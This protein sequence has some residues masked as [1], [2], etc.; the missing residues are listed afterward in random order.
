MNA[1]E[2]KKSSGFMWNVIGGGLVACQSAF[3]MFLAARFYSQ[4]EAGMISSA[5][6]IAVLAFTASRYGMRNYQVT[7][8]RDEFTFRSYYYSRHITVIAVILLVLVYLGVSVYF[9]DYSFNKSLLVLEIVLLRSI[10]SFEDVYLG[11]FQQMGYFAIG[12]RI[13]ALR[14]MALLICMC[15]GMMCRLSLSAVFLCGIVISALMDIFL[16]HEKKDYLFLNDEN[17]TGNDQIVKL[18]K[19]CFPLCLGT[20]LAIYASNIPKYVAD[21]YLD[22]L[23]QAIVGYLMLPIFVIALF[24][25]FI[26]TP[27]IKKLGDLWN[28]KEHSEFYKR[29]ICQS[30]LII[31][32]TIL[33][34]VF[35]LVIGLPILS[36]VYD[37][38]LSPYR[39]EFVVML[40]GGALYALEYYLAIPVT[41]IHEQK[42]LAAAYIISILVA[43]IY[44]KW[45][46][47]EYGLKGVAYLYILVNMIITLI[48]ISI[49]LLRKA[50]FKK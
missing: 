35:M 15:I 3:L 31:G 1:K 22:E 13:M 46:V 12:A 21:W 26:Y 28:E 8:K 25:Q 30:I 34:L 4:E 19:K 45:I 36:L 17:D 2:N 39:S 29:I 47:C 27:F 16:I 10:N 44:Q 41:I 11:R 23:S 5:Y 6:A 50:E 7:D 9:S 37:I 43:L 14:E 49:L 40:I 33:V 42:K 48:F 20:S 32:M 18:L 24:N 38:D